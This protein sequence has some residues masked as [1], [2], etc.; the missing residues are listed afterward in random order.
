MVLRN[1]ARVC[2]AGCICNG[3][4]CFGCSCESGSSGGVVAVDVRVSESKSGYWRQG[5]IRVGAILEPRKID[6]HCTK[7]GAEA[8]ARRL[9]S[10]WVRRGYSWE[11]EAY[12]VQGGRNQLALWGVRRVVPPPPP[13]T[14]APA[15]SPNAMPIGAPPRDKIKNF[16]ADILREQFPTVPVAAVFGSTKRTRGKKYKLVTAARAVAI[17]A[18]HHAFG[19]SVL[20]LADLFKIDEGSARYWLDDDFRARRVQAMFE[21]ERAK[22]RAKIA[23]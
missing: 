19:Y 2:V 4:Y 14:P 11:F 16:V 22:A 21:R 3:S 23:A 10:Y 7:P 1:D 15:I 12:Y 18:V 17:K 9:T 5:K 6:D 20:K 8:L 13:P